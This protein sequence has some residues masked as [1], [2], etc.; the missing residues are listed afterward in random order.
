VQLLEPA[1]VVEGQGLGCTTI[2]TN[3]T[4]TQSER[5][6]EKDKTHARRRTEDWRKTHTLQAEAASGVEE[7]TSSTPTK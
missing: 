2:T 4:G 5:I 7:G 3:T 6:S 1:A